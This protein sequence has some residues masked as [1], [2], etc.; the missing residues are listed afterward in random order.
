MRALDIDKGPA[1]RRPSIKPCV[2]RLA[3]WMTVVGVPIAPGLSAGM[4]GL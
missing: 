1:A 2:E 4:S 3:I